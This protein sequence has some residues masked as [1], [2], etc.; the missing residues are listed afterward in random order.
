MLI[1]D[2]INKNKFKKWKY[3]NITIGY[4]NESTYNLSKN[5][6]YYYFSKLIKNSENLKSLIL[7]PNN[8]NICYFLSLRF[9]KIKNF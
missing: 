7:H 1:K 2:I 6:F 8:F 5:H 4:I 9:K 3:I